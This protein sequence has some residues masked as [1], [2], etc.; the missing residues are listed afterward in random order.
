LLMALYRDQQIYLSHSEV[1]KAKD[2]V[3]ATKK[4]T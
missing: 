3:G 2:F 1:S 4:E